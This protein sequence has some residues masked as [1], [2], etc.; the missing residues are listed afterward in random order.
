MRRGNKAGNKGTQFA[1]IIFSGETL[2]K[3][4]KTRFSAFQSMARKFYLD[5]A[6]WRDYFEDR[7][8]GIRPLGEFA[9]G[10]LKY[11]MDKHIAVIVSDAVH[12]ELEKDYPKERI[13]SL[14]SYF[15][16]IIIEI[17]LSRKQYIEAE[18][19]W[20]KLEKTIPINDIRHAV[21]AKDSNAIMITRDNHFN[22]ISEHLGI[23]VKK[24]EDITYS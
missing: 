14:F 1:V 18:K 6:I 2:P 20:L 23:E 12:F 22:T 4:F 17:Q 15:K 24:P 19:L 11:C 8:D 13:E 10:L 5:T 9:F 7:G 16:D 21:V 3:V